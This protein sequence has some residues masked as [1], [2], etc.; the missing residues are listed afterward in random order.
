MDKYIGIDVHARSC[1]LAVVDGGGKRVGQHVIETN[2]ES[3]VECLRMIPGPRHV[4]N[5]EGT[6]SAWLYEI[7]SPHVQELAVV[8]VASQSRRTHGART[9]ACCHQK[10]PDRELSVPGKVPAHCVS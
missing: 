7:L 6:Q 1:T 5:E 8:N 4:C 2:G 3:L 9:G 10:R